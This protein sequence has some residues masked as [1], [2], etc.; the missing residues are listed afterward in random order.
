MLNLLVFILILSILVVIHEFGHFYAAKRFGVRVEEFG[1]G[2]PPRV[3]GKKI[4]ET[5]YSLNLLPFGGFVKLSGEDDAVSEEEVHKAEKDP[6]NFLSKSPLQRGI[7]I[8]AGVFMNV[9]LAMLLY[10]VFFLTTGF[11]SFSI[12]MFFDYNFRFGNTQT[13]TTAVLGVGEGTPAER[14]GIMQGEAILEI[15]G[16]PVYNL[17][18]VRTNVAEKTGQE[19]RVL[20]MDIKGFE[21]EI[22]TVSL[23]PEADETGVGV[24][25]VYINDVVVLD[26]GR[27]KIF[28]GPAHAYNMTAY[29][30]YT[31][32][33]LLSQSFQQRTIAPVSSSVSGPVGIF[34]IVG[35]IIESGENP[36]LS[37]I[38]LVA[39]LSVSL[40]IINILPFP[41]LDGGRLLF[42]I[43]EKVRGKRLEPHIEIAVHKIGIILLLGLIV[44]ITIRDISRI[45]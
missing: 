14:A 3:I 42:I 4:G 17:Q 5:L 36:L 7:I 27:N 6:R 39:L 13:Y 15:D 20:L 26:Y 41:A 31:F 29:S 34:S 33:H 18:D 45:I 35:S 22:R 10:Y 40:A 9:L 1:F 43:I 28:S 19:V 23:I 11:K 8:V 16:V 21:R 38:D 30:L 25:G 32:S 44:L 37:L 12:P 2:L 24:L